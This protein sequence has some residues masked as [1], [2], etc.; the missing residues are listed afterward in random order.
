MPG[1]PRTREPETGPS[2]KLRFPQWPHVKDLASAFAD[3]TWHILVTLGTFPR[4]GPLGTL[5]YTRIINGFLIYG[6]EDYSSIPI[7]QQATCLCS[8]GLPWRLRSFIFTTWR[9]PF[10]RAQPMLR[11]KA[12]TQ[13]FPSHVEVSTFR[14]RR[15]L[16]GKNG[17]STVKEH[18]K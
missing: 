1:C 9:C 12:T 14:T 18:G 11:L 6:G 10:A 4:W 13:P 5:G 16:A 8:V 3:P 17:E 15:V 2:E 7:A